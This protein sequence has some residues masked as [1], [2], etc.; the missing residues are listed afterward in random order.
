MFIRNFR[1]DI[2]VKSEDDSGFKSSKPETSE[3]SLN[4]IKHLDNDN[5]DQIIGINKDSFDDD[6]NLFLLFI[7]FFSKVIK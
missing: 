2:E 7:I 6:C 1:I 5:N 4:K 3:E